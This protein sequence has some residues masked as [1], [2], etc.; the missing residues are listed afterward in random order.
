MFAPPNK[1]SHNIVSQ[2]SIEPPKSKA[3]AIS[4]HPKKIKRKDG[5]KIGRVYNNQIDPSKYVNQFSGW[6]ART[7]NHR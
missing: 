1:K 5:E 3:A 2:I 6:R 4:T 7:E